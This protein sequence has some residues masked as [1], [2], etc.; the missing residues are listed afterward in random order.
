MSRTRIV[1]CGSIS[2]GL[3]WMINSA[4]RSARHPRKLDDP[5]LQTRVPPIE[6]PWQARAAPLQRRRQV[7]FEGLGD[8][9]E[10]VGR[11]E[12]EPAAFDPRDG[13]LRSP[14]LRGD[15]RLPESKLKADGSNSGAN[16]DSVHR[17]SMDRVTARRPTSDSRAARPSGPEMSQEAEGTPSQ[18]EVPSVTSKPT[19]PTNSWVTEGVCGTAPDWVSSRAE[20]SRSMVK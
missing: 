10:N 15:I 6:Q 14:G 12:S 17:L 20:P 9:R 7:R 11:H 19:G 8:G 1:S 5:L 18:N 3:V 4:R 2:S 16:A 13:L